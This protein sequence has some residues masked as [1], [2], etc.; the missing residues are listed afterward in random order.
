MSEKLYLY[1][2][3]DSKISNFTGPNDDRNEIRKSVKKYS[4]IC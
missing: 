4:L 2:N 3:I 1:V